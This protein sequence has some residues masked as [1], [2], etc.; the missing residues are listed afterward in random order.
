MPHRWGVMGTG[1]IAAALT[2]AAVA[3][4]SEVVAVSSASAERARA[5]ADDHGIP[6]SYGAHHDLLADDQVEVVYVATTNDRHHADVLACVRAGMPVLAEKPFALNLGQATEVVD[7]ARAGDSFVME[8]MW[9]RF[10][11]AFLEVERRIAEGQ[12]GPPTAIQADFG[13]RATDPTGRLLTSALGGGALLDIG[14]YPLTLALSL[15]GEPQDVQAIAQLGPDGVDEQVAASMRHD[16]GVS[17]W[18]ATFMADT[19]IEATVAGPDGSLR[20]HSEFH[21][22]SHVSLRRGRGHV[23]ETVEVPGAELGYQHEVREVARCLDAGLVESPRMTWAFTLT[24]MHWLDE[25]RRRIGVTYP[26]E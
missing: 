1:R 4:G 3:E 11:P 20:L 13:F 5:F 10:Q 19:G 26:G 2:A 12:I 23:V 22:A 17:G 14:V 24:V 16:D 9:M 25:I 18:L 6:R 8:A 7:A 21:H 15:L